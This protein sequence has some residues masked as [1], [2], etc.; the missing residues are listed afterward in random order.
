MSRSRM[1]IDNLALT[2][3][4][5]NVNTRNRIRAWIKQQRVSSTMIAFQDE[6]G[7]YDLCRRVVIYDEELNPLHLVIKTNPE[8]KHAIP[9]LY[10]EFNPNT[11]TPQIWKQIKRI[12]KQ[13]L[14]GSFPSVIERGTVAY[15]HVT[16]D[17]LYPG[18]LP[19]LVVKMNTDSGEAPNGFKVTSSA[20]FDKCGDATKIVHDF[21]RNKNH[22]VGGS[23]I[24]QPVDDATM[25]TV[26]HGM[27][28]DLPI[29]ALTSVRN[30]FYDVGIT[31][32]T[33][34]APKEDAPEEEE[35]R[36]SL[37]LDSVQV[38]G[39]RNALLMLPI[40]ERS[41]YRGLIK[42]AKRRF[43][44]MERR[45]DRHWLKALTQSRLTQKP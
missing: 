32:F 16:Y 1:Y 18:K 24:L 25:I 11:A 14:P 45:W 40:E 4:I 21:S 5:N 17:I 19:N 12:I 33:T 41:K 23:L 10:I 20:F 29:A 13:L 26:T 42:S 2:M 43:I 9:F 22:P 34:V 15:I 38:R 30:K 44:N 27:D 8:P 37:L 6:A 3:E 28:M 31:D 36:F 35:D 39:E 7:K